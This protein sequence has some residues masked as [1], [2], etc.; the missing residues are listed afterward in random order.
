MRAA[1]RTPSVGSSELES[2]SASGRRLDSCT[3]SCSTG[4]IQMITNASSDQSAGRFHVVQ[5]RPACT[6]R[7]RERADAAR[8]DERQVADVRLHEDARR[9]DGEH[10]RARFAHGEHP[11]EQHEEWEHRKRD[12]RVPRVEHH[13]RA[14]RTVG[15]AHERERGEEPRD[16]AGTPGNVRDRG[17]DDRLHERVG[18]ESAPRRGAGE[19]GHGREQVVGGRPRMVPAEAAVRT[20][21]RYFGAPHVADA[22]VHQCEVADGHVLVA[23]ASRDRNDERNQ[24]DQRQ[25]DTEDDARSPCGES[26]CARSRAVTV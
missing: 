21:E 10:E 12:V 15:E 5:A 7:E 23:G 3:N 13:R 18:D 8:D 24:R 6:E 14:H 2:E 22:Q 9:D 1:S 20:D 11:R 26:R 25:D 4:G 16:P 17:D 19:P